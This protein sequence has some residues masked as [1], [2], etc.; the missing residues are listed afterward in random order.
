[1]SV[2]D[3][4]GQGF[5]ACLQNWRAIAVWLLLSV[6]LAPLLVFP[7]LTLF[8]AVWLSYVLAQRSTGQPTSLAAGAAATA[9]RIPSVALCGL[10][11]AGVGLFVSLLFSVPLIGL[12]A[13]LYLT[14]RVFVLPTVLALEGR[15]GWGSLKR[16]W[17]IT[18]SDQGWCLLLV[19]VFLSLFLIG[20]LLWGLSV[21]A[22]VVAIVSG[23]PTALL[24]TISLICAAAAAA[25]VLVLLPLAV[26]TQ[27][28][29]YRRLQAFDDTGRS[30]M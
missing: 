2:W 28:S 29:A 24:A 9:R 20:S 26:A 27:T 23:G 16:A 5:K 18:S 19:L 15:S 6:P 4:V 25:L 10:I 11:V 8:W 14:A 12:P 21:G 17:G 13:T 7:P 22:G 3:A 1:M 30:V